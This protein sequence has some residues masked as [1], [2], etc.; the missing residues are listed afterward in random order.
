MKK[1]MKTGFSL[2]ALAL[3]CN[4]AFGGI[5]LEEFAG[6]WVRENETDGI[7]KMQITVGDGKLKIHTWGDC[8]PSDCDWGSV[9][10]DPATSST[11]GDYE[12][13]TV[14]VLARYNFSYAQKVLLIIPESDKRLKIQ[15]FTEFNDERKNMFKVQ[16]LKLQPPPPISA[17]PAPPA[18]QPAPPAVVRLPRPDLISPCGKTYDH[19]PRETTLR[20]NEVPGATGYLVEIDCL[21]CCQ[22]GKWCSEVGGMWKSDNTSRT[23]YTFNWVGANKGR[24]RVSAIDQLGDKQPPSDWCYFDYTR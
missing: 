23:S 1:A 3:A 21:H 4:L 14:A 18:K 8:T 10:A 7:T 9:Y 12:R 22:S 17:R 16:Y 20:W 19:Y 15:L 24:W 5:P 6:T 13:N 11:S 2:F